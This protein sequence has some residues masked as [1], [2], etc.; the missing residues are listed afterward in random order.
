MLNFKKPE[1]DDRQWISECIK[2]VHSMNCEYTFGNMFL[3]RDA[4][5]TE[6]AKYDDFVICRWSTDCGYNYS[7][8]L[9][10]GDFKAAVS[11]IIANAS[12]NGCVAQIYGVTE[13]YKAV[14]DSDFDDKF[15]YTYD[16]GNYDY[17]YNVEDLA[18]LSGKKYHSKR[19]HITNFK[20]NNPDWSFE[21]IDSDN[22]DECIKLHT[23]WIYN[24][25]DNDNETDYSLE[26]Q[27]VLNG[28]ENYDKIGFLG[29]L[30]RIGGKPVAYTFGEALSPFCFVTHFEKAPADMQGAY[31]VINQEFARL[32]HEHGFKFVNREED[33]G[34]EGL[35]KAKQSYKPTIW[36]QK[37]VAVYND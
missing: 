2:H 34:I 32:L 19:N 18:N 12:E 15:T 28:F 17:I 1:I 14:L 9:G 24:K 35:R 11:E 29:G 5:K 20:K 26:F 31:A 23:E 33:L 27:A 7:L 37:G 4:Y 13:S 16:S 8:P 30:I 21:I 22:I 3:W 6:V 36:L 25:E 10:E